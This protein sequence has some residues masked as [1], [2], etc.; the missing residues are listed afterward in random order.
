[1]NT[2]IEPNEPL[3]FDNPNTKIHYGFFPE[4]VAVEDEK[5]V[6]DAEKD[7]ELS[8][9]LIR[10]RPAWAWNAKMQLSKYKYEKHEGKLKFT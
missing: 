3:F 8:G 1:M 9:I 7:N 2:S 4:I 5:M 10:N 6:T